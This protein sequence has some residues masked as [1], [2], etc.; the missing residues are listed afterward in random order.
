MIPCFFVSDLH[1]R[2]ERYRKLLS[3]IRAEKPRVVFIGGD[4]LP[5]PAQR[6]AVEN[7]YKGSFLT[8]FWIPAIRKLREEMGTDFPQ[9]FL[10]MGNDDARS[11]E[12][13]LLAGDEE[14]LWL[15]CHNKK[16]RFENFAVYGYANVPPTPFLLKDWERYD[17]SRYVDPGCVSPEEGFRTVANSESETKYGTIQNDLLKLT[18]GDDISR[19][20]FLFHSP[21][22]KTAL[23][24]AALDGKS[25]EHVPLDV[26]IGSIAIR[27]FIE[28]HKPYLTL[29][30][31]VHE[32]TRLTGTW[33][34]GI[35]PTSMF[36]ASHDGSE[37]ALIRFNLEELKKAERDLL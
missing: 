35:G 27:R 22:Y 21:P 28:S 2:I 30:G 9:V 1:G 6:N 16:N 23:D 36:N 11:E 32:S 4:L 34:D 20:V 3:A 33:R 13:D 10:I 37:L 24:R 15:Y 8:G 5:H 26:H 14:G 17:C 31:H 18:N 29:H 12:G 7:A 19:A 25:V